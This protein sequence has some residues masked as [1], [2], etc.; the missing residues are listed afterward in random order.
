M[1]EY[2]QEN[3]HLLGNKY[4]I[5]KTIGFLNVHATLKREQFLLIVQIKFIVQN[6]KIFYDPC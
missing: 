5:L 1:A 2:A 4:K 6:L 3:I